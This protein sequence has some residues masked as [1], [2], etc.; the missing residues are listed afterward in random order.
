MNLF[1]INNT[2][3]RILKGGKIGLALSIALLSP[4]ASVAQE[5]FNTTSSGSS[6]SVQWREG[7]PTIT[8]TSKEVGSDTTATYN[9]TGEDILF[10]VTGVDKKI[11]GIRLTSRSWGIGMNSFRDDNI[12]DGTTTTEDYLD[13]YTTEADGYNWGFQAYYEEIEQDNNNTYVITLAQ[14]ASAGS[15]KKQMNLLTLREGVYYTDAYNSRE[16]P[17]TYTSNIILEGNNAISDQ[18]DIGNGNITLNGSA[19]FSNSEPISISVSS[20]IPASDIDFVTAGSIDINTTEN[21]VFNNKVSLD[22][23]NASQTL[24]YNAAG[25]VTLGDNEDGKI[26]VMETAKV[27]GVKDG[28]DGNIDFNGQNGTLELNNVLISG[29]IYSNKS[30]N[31]TINVISDTAEVGNINVI[32]NLNM[33]TTGTL[34]AKN[35]NVENIVFN[36]AG[37]LNIN[38]NLTSS[39]GIKF[40]TFD[41]TVKIKNGSLNA[42]ITTDTNDNGSVILAGGEQNINKNI[43]SDDLKIKLL[44]IGDSGKTSTTT[45]NSDVYATDVRVHG[46][47]TLI[48]AENKMIDANITTNTNKKGTFILGGGTQSII[49]NIGTADKEFE[50]IV[51]A[52]GSESVS[53]FNETV[54]AETIK[55]ESGTANFNKILNS[56]IV[57]EGSATANFDKNVNGSVLF[58]NSD[59][60]ANIKGSSNVSEG[61]TSFDN[62]QGTVTFDSAVNVDFTLG[63]DG[64]GLKLASFA[65]D[66]NISKS[67]YSDEIKT[68]GKNINL[69]DGINIKDTDTSNSV[70]ITTA[71]NETGILTVEGTSTVDASIGQSGTIFKQ[72]NAG[73]DDKTVSLNGIVYTEKL[74]FS[75]DGTVILGGHSENNSKE[76][77][78]GTVDLASGTG[79]LQVQDGVNLTVGA[80]GATFINN[81]NATLKFNANSSITGDV[82]QNDDVFETIYAGATDSTVKI[83]GDVTAKTLEYTG[84]GTIKI[85]GT[86]SDTVVDFKT[87]DGRLEIANGD[88]NATLTHDANEATLKMAS[89][90]QSINEQISDSDNLLKGL[91][92]GDNSTTTANVD[93]FAIQTTLGNSEGSTLNLADNK[94]ITSEIKASSNSKGTLRLN[95]GTQTV[96]GDVGTS[97]EKLYRVDSGY[98]VSNFD[99]NVSAYNIIV[100][101][102][103]TNFV[104]AVTADTTTIGSGTAN[105]NTNDT[106]ATNTA[107]VFSSDNGT[108]NLHTGLVGNIDFENHSA[109]VNVWD[110]QTLQ[111]NI[112]STGGVGGTINV[113]GSGEIIGN[114]G[115][116]TSNGIQALNLNTE[117]NAGEISAIDG[118]VYAQALNI[119]NNAILELSDSKVMVGTDATAL[120]GKEQFITTSANKTG[121]LKLAGNNTITGVV[122]TSSKALKLI[123]AGSDNNTDTFNNMVHTETLKFSGDGTVVLNAKAGV[124]SS[125]AGIKGKVDLANT[126]GQLQIGDSVNLATGSTGINIANAGN[127]SLKFNGSST[128]NGVVGGNSASKS[129]FKS[130]HAGADKKTVTFNNDLHVSENTTLQV[131]AIDTNNALPTALHISGTGTVNL[132]GDLHSD[133][134]YDTDGIVNI[135]NSKS[136]KIKQAPLA[137]KTLQDKKGTLNYLGGTT[138]ANSDIGESGKKLKS[139]NFNTNSNNVHQIID[140]DIYAYDTNIGGTRGT[141]KLSLADTTGSY[142][143]AGATVLKEFRGGTSANITKDITFDGS[144]TLKNSTSALN[145]NTSRIDVLDNLALN[146]GGVSFTV[147]TKDITGADDAKA[148][149]ED[150]GH[151]AVAKELKVTGNEKFHINYVGSLSDTGTYTLIDAKT[152]AGNYY[153]KEVSTNKLITDNSFSIDTKVYAENNKVVVAADRTNGGAYEAE[154]LYVVKSNTSGH[155]SNN[156]AKALADI[157]A[158]GSQHDDMVEVIQKFELDS[159]GYGN[160]QE[161]LALQVKKLAPIANNSLSQAS[162]SASDT[163]TTTVASRMSTVRGMSA[164]DEV[165]DK[166]IWGKVI[167]ATATQDKVDIYDGYEL[168]SNGISLGMD[169]TIIE[170]TIIGGSMGY[171]TTAVTQTDLRENDAADVT[172]LQASIYGSHVYGDYYV[173]GQLGYAMHNTS[174]NRETAID[175]KAAYDTDATQLQL[176]LTGAYNYNYNDIRI[177]PTVS[178]NY[179]MFEQDA[180]TETGAG[181]LNLSVESESLARGSFGVGTKVEKDVSMLNGIYTPQ[182]RLGVDK[183]FGDNG[184]ATVAKFEQGAS[185][186][187]ESSEMMSTMYTVGAGIKTK[188]TDTVSISLDTNYKQSDTSY[189]NMDLQLSAEIKF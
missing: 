13:G 63:E 113:K 19:D 125:T 186:T 70:G 115:T 159:F 172:S 165:L 33:N 104:K 87:N 187:T 84:E 68:A 147:N 123:E 27:T 134:I 74:L 189:S 35:T 98:G 129:T 105:F 39:D 102:G 85:D 22:Q 100:N 44:Q 57:F 96:T 47:S 59:A 130:I 135:A 160:T 141:T 11:V 180:Y 79:E 30:T 110:N 4:M 67:I 62:N 54:Y 76:G 28:L 119:K 94:N 37:A 162:L 188:V 144:L 15:I 72:V 50:E 140:Q 66:T 71:T 132:N 112:K 176:N 122:G 82:G 34:S 183:Y 7:E 126:T 167:S 146:N 145:I 139:I 128:I 48:L 117:G 153:Q 161:K 9:S 108:A 88:L 86:L 114:V 2:R 164:G 182:L 121:T 8:I 3:F 91:E 23:E 116:S 80:D 148:T 46:D 170:N 38:G 178:L 16:I 32:K 169:K 154:E 6:Y 163:V 142:D 45:V 52:V 31:G 152:I 138:L 137:V 42:A 111:G 83:N 29:D 101:E 150:S 118:N 18:V 77:V 166:L 107:L 73:V 143:Y 131:S 136:V 78:V 1:R 92:I 120:T 43:G 26:K 90:T 56:D 60:T 95:G 55:L 20:S 97:D 36:E 171:L 173:E 124:N 41:A 99:G 103:T 14:D 157:S 127:S 151:I 109:S 81:T 168:S 155:F 24:T 5:F 21:I 184:V 58:K 179:S 174:G 93:I 64:H 10:D 25:T 156:A 17:S 49:H 149:T 40:Q 89:R 51:A 177:I 181:A 61:F 65:E 69:K 158:Q 106:D 53:N 133:L 12:T 175:R 75:G 185:F